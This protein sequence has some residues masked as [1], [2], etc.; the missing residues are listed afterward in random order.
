MLLP[1]NKMGYIKHMAVEHEMV[2]TYAERDLALELAL[3]KALENVCKI[4]L[5]TADTDQAVGVADGDDKD[6]GDHQS[7]T[8]A[9]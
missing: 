7:D 9:N 1:T 5:P 4:T 6:A 3:N 8:D 2:M